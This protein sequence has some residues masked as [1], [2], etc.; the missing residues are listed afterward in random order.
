MAEEGLA[1]FHLSDPYGQKVLSG[2]KDGFDETILENATKSIKRK[3]SQDVLV[4][5]VK[6]KSYTSS[7]CLQEKVIH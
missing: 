1:L 4:Q 2:K 3:W 7:L 6:I 5:I